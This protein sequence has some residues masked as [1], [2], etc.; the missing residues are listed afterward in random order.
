MGE[1]VGN[2]KVTREPGYL[3]Y[4]S[5]KGDVARVKRGTKGSQIVL[6]GAV[7]RQPGYLYYVSKSGQVERTRMARGKQKR[8]R[9]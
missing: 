5:G 7:V 1:K 6:K 3:Y 8:M 9:G 4:V 2:A